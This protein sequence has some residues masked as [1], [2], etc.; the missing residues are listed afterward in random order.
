MSDYKYTPK[1]QNNQAGPMGAAMIGAALLLFCVATFIQRGHASLQI[2][3]LLLGTLG[4]YTVTRYTLTSFRYELHENNLVVVKIVGKRE[5]TV[6]DLT[7]KTARGIFPK[8][9]AEAIREAAPRISESHN[10]TCTM[11]TDNTY[12]Y[13]YTDADRYCTLH[14][15]PD[16]AF[17]SEMKARMTISSPYDEEE[18]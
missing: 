3:G 12:V 5:M 15:E 1:P 13:V 8:T 7:L 16:D 9:D 17:L 10:Y 14:L 11:M 2:L 4:I 6:C 18:M